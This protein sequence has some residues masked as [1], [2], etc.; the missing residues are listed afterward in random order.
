MSH[1]AVRAEDKLVKLHGIR[2]EPIG[3][4]RIGVLGI[5][6]IGGGID[7][8]VYID[9]EV[10][11]RV[12][13][14]A[15]VDGL[16]QGIVRPFDGDADQGISLVLPAGK[17]RRCKG[18]RQRPPGGRSLVPGRL[19]L[20]F[21]LLDVGLPEP[22]EETRLDKRATNPSTPVSWAPESALAAGCSAPG[23]GAA[24]GGVPSAAAGVAGGVLSGM[25]RSDAKSAQARPASNA[26]AEMKVAQISPTTVWRAPFHATAPLVKPRGSSLTLARSAS[27][28]WATS[29]LACASG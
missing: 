15:A 18:G 5:A 28:G 2:I 24:A 23:T 17:R 9:P 8:A 29:F 13:A 20:R 11:E 27:E 10:L 6:P 7:P 3:G 26:S 1:E 12:A 4:R 16:L 19:V 25:V 21:E 22:A 14:G